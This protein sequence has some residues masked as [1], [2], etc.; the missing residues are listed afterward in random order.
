MKL[1]QKSSGYI[2]CLFILLLHNS[3]SEEKLSTHEIYEINSELILPQAKKATNKP[4][5]ESSSCRTEFRLFAPDSE[6]NDCPFTDFGDIIF[7][8][9]FDF[10]NDPYFDFDLVNYYLELQKKY[11]THYRGDNYFGESGEYNHLADKRTRELEKFWQLERSV[12]VNGQ[13]TAFL[14]DRDI[15]ASMIESFDRSVRNRTEAYAKADLLLEINALSSTIPESPYFAMDGFTKSNGLLVIG[16]GLIESIV[17]LGVDEKVVFTGIISHEW[18]H[19]AQ[20]EYSEIW[21]D[22]IEFELDWEK[23][24]FLELE[25]DFAAA[26]FMTHKRGATYNW[27]RIEDFFEVSYNIGDCLIESTNH[28]GTPNQRLEAARLGYELAAEAQHKGFILEPQAV[29]KYFIEHYTEVL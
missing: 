10:F 20:F 3:C 17:N 19:Q 18:W 4:A 22:I 12:I 13:H 24:R 16:D 26:Y 14:D 7:S 2:I 27:K 8:Y 25:A 1:F 6:L 28:H 23:S 21:E 5:T 9:I 11:V 29:H 15:L